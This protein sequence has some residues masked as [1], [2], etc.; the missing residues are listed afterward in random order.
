MFS[1]FWILTLNLIR[2]IILKF[3][4]LKPY[5]LVYKF[6]DIINNINNALECHKSI[7]F[8]QHD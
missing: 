8:L 1:C 2:L 7:I 4:R 6:D 5:S 3:I